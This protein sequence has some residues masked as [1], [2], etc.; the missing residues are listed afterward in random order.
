MFKVGAPVVGE[1]FIGRNNEIERIISA[2]KSGN[3]ISVYGMARIGK[4]SIIKE[5]LRKANDT[6]IF[7]KKP[8]FFE[9]RLTQDKNIRYHFFEDLKDFIIDMVDE[10]NGEEQA[11]VDS[12]KRLLMRLDGG[13][14]EKEVSHERYIRLCNKITELYDNDIWIILDEMDYANT[15]FGSYIQKIREIVTADRVHVINISRHSLTSIFPA[16]GNG[17]NYP[18]VV[19]QN[20]PIIGFSEEDMIS[21][22][23][24]FTAE[25]G[26]EKADT[27]WENMIEYAGNVPYFLALLTNE[28]ISD[29]NAVICDIAE[30]PYGKYAETLKYWYQ[31]LYSDNMLDNAISLIENPSQAETTNLRVFGIIQNGKFSVPW[32]SRYIQMQNNAEQS[33]GLMKEYYEIQTRIPVLLSRG[34]NISQGVMRDRETLKRINTCLR[35]LEAMNSKIECMRVLNEK[36]TF[37]KIMPSVE[38]V[39]FFDTKIRDIND[40]FEQLEG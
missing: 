4:S 34:N 28:I 21:F 37:V 18:G 11:K 7:P 6:E 10:Y 20:I 2:M 3:N 8:L 30:N 27:I 22:K 35:E 31:S 39:N 32:F 17:S 24:R 15:A 36:D 13:Q 9:Y 23:E 16:H 38:E 19:T 33:S 26:T 29:E 1:D 40:L 14:N 5:V 12:L 25:I